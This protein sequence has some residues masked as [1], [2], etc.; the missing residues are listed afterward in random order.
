MTPRRRTATRLD[1]LAHRAGMSPD[2]LA[3][4][5]GTAAT[6]VGAV[7]FFYALAIATAVLHTGGAL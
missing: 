2:E 3:D 6:I 1:I 7:V 4:A 5:I